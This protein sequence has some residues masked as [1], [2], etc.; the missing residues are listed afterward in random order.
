LG[1]LSEEKYIEINL[2]SIEIEKMLSSLI[3]KLKK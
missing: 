3:S 1:Y 2:L